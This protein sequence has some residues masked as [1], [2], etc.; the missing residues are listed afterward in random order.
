MQDMGGGVWIP[1]SGKNSV[2]HLPDLDTL[3]SNTGAFIERIRIVWVD[4]K[5]K[6]WCKNLALWD[7]MKRAG[8]IL[9]LKNREML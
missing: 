3:L 9:K 5:K 7:P 6:T 4:G 8:P 2:A 1:P